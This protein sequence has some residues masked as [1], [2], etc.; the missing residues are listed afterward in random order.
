MQLLSTEILDWVNPKDNY[1]NDSPKSCFLLVDLDYP[2]EL[3][4]LHNDYP[5]AGE[6]I[7]KQKK[8]CPNINYK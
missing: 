5:L 2:D 6:K 4:D 8:R 7:K 3:H 1:S